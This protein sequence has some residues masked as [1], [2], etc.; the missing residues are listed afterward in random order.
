MKLNKTEKRQIRE[1]YGDLS[2]GEYILAFPNPDHE[3]Q[4]NR[5]ISLNE[6]LRIFKDE[7]CVDYN[8]GIPHSDSIIEKHAFIKAFL[9]MGQYDPNRVPHQFVKDEFNNNYLYQT[10]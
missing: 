4:S 7:I 1:S 9:Q 2:I 6:A 5:S 3:S 8:H 10:Q